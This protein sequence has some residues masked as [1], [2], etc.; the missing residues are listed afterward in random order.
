M[1]IIS[2]KNLFLVVAL[3]LAGCGK[4]N[5]KDSYE[6]VKNTA[7]EYGLMDT[8]ESKCTSSKMLGASMKNYYKFSGNEFVKTTE[9]STNADC[10]EPSMTM[11]YN[12]EFKVADKSERIVDARN[13]D[14]DYKTATLLPST[15]AGVTLLNSIS[16]CGKTDYEV[17][18]KKEL[19]AESDNLLCPVADIPFKRY[20]II[21]VDHKKLFLGIGEEDDMALAEDRSGELDLENPYITSK[22]ELKID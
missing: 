14:F 2:N 22:H 8:W 1:K 5:V 20:D 21:K 13:I 18:K 9:F 11:Q 6:G 12:G 19:T 3:V 16:F 15:I 10:V 4:D 17:G 7:R